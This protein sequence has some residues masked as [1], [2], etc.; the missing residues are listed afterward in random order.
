[1][2][3]HLNVNLEVPVEVDTDVRLFHMHDETAV[4][5]NM[6]AGSAQEHSEG[7][8]TGRQTKFWGAIF[9]CPQCQTR[10]ISEL[11]IDTRSGTGSVTLGS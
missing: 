4:P 10:S 7:E 8:P 1:M 11:H 2:D 9:Q 5:M 6:V 3:E